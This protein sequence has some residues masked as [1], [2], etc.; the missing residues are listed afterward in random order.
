MLARKSYFKLGRFFVGRNQTGGLNNFIEAIDFR[1]LIF[2]TLVCKPLA[3][4]LPHETPPTSES[5][6]SLRPRQV[7][8][9]GPM[10]HENGK[11]ASQ[12]IP[13][14]A[15]SSSLILFSSSGIS[16][17][18]VPGV[19]RQLGR[20]WPIM[21]RLIWRFDEGIGIWTAT[22]GYFTP[23][24]MERQTR[25]RFVPAPIVDP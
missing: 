25:D 18:L 2:T 7:S 14:L 9:H 4:Q 6:S 11:L 10:H 20:D 12:H 15:N 17:R 24:S 13:H 5:Q 16:H 1:D 3:A 19:S 22:D 8:K 23:S 21:I